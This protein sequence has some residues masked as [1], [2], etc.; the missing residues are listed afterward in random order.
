MRKMERRR[1]LSAEDWRAVLRRFKASGRSAR[2]FCEREG[3]GLVSFYAWR[4][5]LRAQSVPARGSGKS[6]APE[7]AG[8]FVE[9]GA[10]GAKEPRFEVRLDLGAGVLLHLVRG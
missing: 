2:A 7:T 8:G 5:R 10:L 9:L 3:L 6:N 1:R 4:R